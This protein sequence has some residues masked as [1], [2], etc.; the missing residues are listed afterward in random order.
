MHENCRTQLEH[1]VVPAALRT[2][3]TIR[4][5][6]T[7]RKV[8]AVSW[9]W[10]N[11]MPASPASDSKDWS[12]MSD[13]QLHRLKEVVGQ[14][15]FSYLWVDWACVPQRSSDTMKFINASYDIYSNAQKVVFIPRIKQ[16]KRRGW[17]RL[18]R[19][20]AEDAI[21]VVRS[22]A[23]EVLSAGAFS[24]GLRNILRDSGRA[25]RLEV[26]LKALHDRRDEIRGHLETSMDML[27]R[28]LKGEDLVY[29]TFDYYARAWTLAE[30][31]AAFKPSNDAPVRL[32]DM[33]SA[34]DALLY[35][36]ASFWRDV[37]KHAGAYVESG[38]PSWDLS[39]LS[40]AVYLRGVDSSDE[41]VREAWTDM[42]HMV[43]LAPGAWG[44]TAETAALAV[45]CVE[46][47]LHNKAGV[48]DD[49]GKLVAGFLGECAAYTSI[50]VASASMQEQADPEWFRKYMYFQAGSVYSSTVTRDLILAVYRSCGLQERET[51]D[52]AIESCLGEVF[53]ESIGSLDGDSKP[54]IDR[55]C[56]EA[57]R[58]QDLHTYMLSPE[59]DNEIL[60]ASDFAPM[61]PRPRQAAPVTASDFYEW[62]TQSGVVVSW[63]F[64]RIDQAMPSGATEYIDVE[65][66]YCKD[67]ARLDSLSLDDVFRSAVT[68]V[69]KLH[70]LND[71]KWRLAHLSFSRQAGRCGEG[72]SPF[73][74]R[75][76]LTL[77]KL[78]SPGILRGARAQTDLISTWNQR[79]LKSLDEAVHNHWLQCISSTDILVIS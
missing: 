30:R 11:P 54:D 63:W 20:A 22:A 10:S 58:H 69:Y 6:F 52:E 45:I 19:R 31:L 38:R 53:G 4:Q 35:G 18:S 3:E 40:M 12:P 17:P 15:Q 44:I 62:L 68:I 13:L 47:L 74:N 43:Q 76:G 23:L 5:E 33:Q 75:Q 37:Q 48:S 26:E 32:G 21:A 34:G 59:E 7:R 71:R 39:D 29:P 9:R 8:C 42:N 14:S 16:L 79:C 72:L 70:R 60:S 25:N 64:S 66:L 49:L 55:L 41:D 36:M 27:L 56:R 65:Q 57:I 2:E 46:W 73:R 77:E 61:M 28:L 51:A 24:E 1:V 50:A 67:I 78:L